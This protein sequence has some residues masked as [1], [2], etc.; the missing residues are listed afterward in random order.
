MSFSFSA[1]NAPAP[2]ISRSITYVFSL[3]DA[4]AAGVWALTRGAQLVSLLPA[5]L[6]RMLGKL[7]TKGVRLYDSMP[8]PDYTEVDV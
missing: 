6:S 4:A 8:V 7:N 1:L 2:G 3:G 5:S